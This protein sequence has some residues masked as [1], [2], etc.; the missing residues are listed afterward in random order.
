[1]MNTLEAHGYTVMLYSNKDG[2]EKFSASSSPITHY[3]CAR[4]PGCQT[5]GI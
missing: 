4:S 5:Q 3:G 2:F 1:M